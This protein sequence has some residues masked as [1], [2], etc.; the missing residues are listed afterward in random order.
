MLADYQKIPNF[1]LVGAAKAGTTSLY[2]YLRQ[3]PDIFM[4]EW[5]ELSFFI[6][7]PCGPLHK[8]RKPAYY[9]KVFSGVKQEK[10][11]GEAS[12]SYL[13]D[14]AA[15]AIIKSRLGPV[16]ILIILRDPVAM[17]YSLYNH[18]S[19]KEGETIADFEAALAAEEERLKDSAFKKKCYG[20]HANYYYFQ[21]G[22]YYEQV[23]RYLDMFGKDHVKIILFDELSAD[24]VGSVQDAYRF[25]DVDD[26]FVPDI[27]VHNPAGGI[28]SIP[29]FW[30]D[31]GLFLKTFQYVFSKNIIKK[32]PHLLRNIGRKPPAPLNPGTARNLRR[33]FY[34]DICRLEQ[35]I[36][37]DLSAWKNEEL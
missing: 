14:R 22:L 21:R 9:Y 24:A 19:R 5:K 20:W 25:L 3:H 6:G 23:L 11:I 27:K 32:I 13:Y 2:E 31:A 34:E 1:L 15:P 37:K 35:L 30:Q 16:K 33:K 26:A 29:R 4:P 8:V 28:I 36:E 10:A 17:S 12:T 7:D 18:Q